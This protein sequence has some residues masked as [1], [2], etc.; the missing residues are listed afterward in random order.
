MEQWEAGFEKLKA[1]Y[2]AWND[3]KGASLSMWLDLLAEEVDFR[4]LANGK[5]GVPW[6]KTR[7]T[8]KEV[9]EYLSG[10]TSAFQMDH[11]T[12]ERYVC[13]GD[14][15]VVIGSTAWH[16]KVSGKRIDTPMVSVWRFK[17][18]KA[19]SFFEYYDTANVA[20]AAAP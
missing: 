12:V 6:T 14:T 3:T 9:S 16:N 4:S 7:T 18:G 17:D 15:V 5:L 1:A 2:R 11:Y 10:L 20:Q 19:I 8:P 13:Q